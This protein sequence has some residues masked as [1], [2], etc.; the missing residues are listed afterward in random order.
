MFAFLS[1]FLQKNKIDLLA[2]LPL[3][4]CKVIRPYLLER[5]HITDGT[6]ILLAVPY[7]SSACA[8]PARNL[9]AY[10]VSRDYHLFFKNLFEEVLPLLRKQYPQYHFAGFADHS[11]IAEV[12]AAA[13]AGLGVI[14]KNRLLI[15]EKYSSYVFLG[16]IFTDAKI[17]CLPHAI[18]SCMECGA[19][20][21]HCPSQN[22]R[23]CLSDLTQKKGVLT[24]DEQ[25]F[26]KAGGMVWGCDVCQEICPHTAQALERGTIFSPIPY[27]NEALIPHL[28]LEDLQGMSEEEFQC[29]SYAWRRRETIERNLKLLE[30]DGKEAPPCSD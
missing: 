19:C 20:Q 16:S 25:R 29:R 5:V 12:H 27:F 4:E 10:A 28:S 23:Q 11:P 13:R 9:S 1:E 21:R 6:A 7:F 24:A 22:G 14:G 17:P 15:T 2:P 3:S 18:K 30:H 8:E 26:L